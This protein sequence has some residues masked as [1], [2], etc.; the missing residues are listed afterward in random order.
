MINTAIKPISVHSDVLGR[1]VSIDELIR[2]DDT[3]ARA[4]SSE[5]KTRKILLQKGWQDT[6]NTTK[7][8]RREMSLQHDLLER[9]GRPLSALT[10]Q[11]KENRDIKRKETNTQDQ[12][13]IRDL[14]E[15]NRAY[16]KRV[17]ELKKQLSLIFAELENILTEESI[18]KLQ[19]KVELTTRD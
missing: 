10:R 3:E 15:E 2:L 1:L 13:Q 5:L 14:L 9:I 8:Q 17:R 19:N 7:E 6:E 11:R 12:R 4:L 18:L 16:S